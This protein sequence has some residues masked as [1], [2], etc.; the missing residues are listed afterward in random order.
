ML[1]IWLY[2]FLFLIGLAIVLA[3]PNLLQ[4]Y[5]GRTATDTHDLS[6]RIEARVQSYVTSRANVGLAVGI[7]QRGEFY[8]KGFSNPGQPVPNANTI[9]EIGSITKVFTG[10]I[11]AQQ[12]LTN[13]VGLDDPIRDYLPAEVS[14]SPEV[15]AITLRQLATHSSGLPR[16]PDNL[17]EGMDENNPYQH[18]DAGK[19]YA[20]LSAMQLDFPPGKGSSYSNLGMGLLGH[21]LSLKTGKSY[22]AL[23]Q[24]TIAQPLQMDNTLIYLESEPLSRLIAGHSSEGAIVPN[25]D[26]AVLSGAGGLRSTVPDL[27]KLVQA[28]LQPPQGQLGAALE[29][30]Q[31]P[32]Q[33][34]SAAV[35]NDT[36]GLGWQRLNPFRQYPFLTLWHNGGTGGYT[37][38]LGIRPDRQCGVVLLSN[39]GDMIANDPSLDRIGMDLLNIAGNISLN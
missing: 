17:A 32:Q 24:E 16:L 25:W 12:A 13:Q 6:D 1:K 35:P 3:S 28:S 14:L 11:L 21:L 37:S 23:I 18:Y 38:W 7:Y 29:L 27:L 34:D 4:L 5:Q 36:I 22:G 30:S 10:I 9:Y 39:Y 19:L 20:A 26:L 8:V 2:I 15:G 33:S 31:Q